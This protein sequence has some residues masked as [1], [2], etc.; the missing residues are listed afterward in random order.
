MRTILSA[1]LV[2]VCSLSLA[3]A[4]DLSF[5][6]LEISQRCADWAKSQGD[7]DGSARKMCL[8]KNQDGYNYARA[9]WPRASAETKRKCLDML[10]KQE[11]PG[12]AQYPLPYDG[13]ASWLADLVPTDDLQRQG[14]FKY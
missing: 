3:S 2:S 7:F 6:K 9:V 13:L 10:R 1:V 4:E 14:E 8:Q 12:R 11:A 5:P